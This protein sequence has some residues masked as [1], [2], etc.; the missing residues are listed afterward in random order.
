MQG[1]E[2][3]RQ[4]DSVMDEDPVDG[5]EPYTLDRG[6]RLSSD[7]SYSKRL[8]DVLGSDEEQD[9]KQEDVSDT[10]DEAADEVAELANGRFHA[11]E[12]SFATEAGSSASSMTLR[13]LR[14]WQFPAPKRL[15]SLQSDQSYFST[16]SPSVGMSGSPSVVSDEGSGR[17]S[18]MLPYGER[19]TNGNG[20]NGNTSHSNSDQMLSGGTLNRSFLRMSRLCTLHDQEGSPTVMTVAGGILAVGTRSGK[21]GLFDR[22]KG[23]TGV[24]SVEG[25]VTSLAISSD[26]TFFGIGTSLGHIYLYDFAKLSMPARHVP[27]VAPNSVAT[28]RSEGHLQG[29][30]VLHLSFVG[31]RRTAIVSA[32]ENGLAFYHSLGKILGVSSN[33]TLRILGKY[34]DLFK[35]SRTRKSTILGMSALPL[36]SHPHASDSNNFVALLTPTKMVLVGLK[37]SAKTWY[38]HLS[39]H[40]D[41]RP[42]SGCLAWM[43]SS[44]VAQISSS[45]DANGQ[46]D[47][48]LAF[49]FG[50]HLH[51][52][53]LRS[54]GASSA[55]QVTAFEET[56][57][58]W[59]HAEPIE[60]M[61]WLSPDYLILYSNTHM[62]LF[63]TRIGKCT[64]EQTII[65]P[66]GNRWLEEDDATTETLSGSLKSHKGSLFILTPKEVLA[67]SLITWAD[68]IL[69]LVSTGNFL[70]AIG[71]VTSLLQDGGK[72]GG[73]RVG[74]PEAFS[75]QKPILA[76]RLMELMKASAKYAFS[77]DRMKDD[78]ANQRGGIDRTPLFEGLARVCA[79]A[80]LALGDF[81]YLFDELF[82]MYSEAGIEAIFADQME[83]FIVS[84]QVRV[85]PIPVV[86]RLISIR[87]KQDRLDLAE[88]IIWNVDP[89][90][91]DLDQV[92]GLC[93]KHDLHDALI[94]VYTRALHDFVGPIVELIDLIKRQ[95]SD[96]YRIISYLSITLIGLSYPNQDKLD[97]KEA[98][99]AR[100][101]LYAFLFSGRCVI[102][103]PGPGGRL[104]LTRDID[105]GDFAE[106]TFP[107]LCLMLHYDAEAFLDALDVALEDAWLDE[108]DTT[109]QDIVSILFEVVDSL[110]NGKVF[111]A[112]FIARNAPKYPQFIRLAPNQVEKLLLIL[113]V[114][115]D[116]EEG[117]GTLQDRQFAVECLLSAYRPKQTDEMLDKFASAGFID[118]LRRVYRS[119][120]K[121]DKLAM[122]IVAGPHNEATLDG[123]NE[124]L[125]KARKDERVQSIFLQ[126]LPALLDVDASKTVAV[127]QRYMAGKQREA[128]R[129]LD[130][131][132]HRQLTY[133]R[134]FLDLLKDKPDA[135]DNDTRNLFIS[136]MCSIEPHSLVKTLEESGQ[137]FF[138][139]NKVVEVA[140]E[141]SVMDGL[142]WAR[143]KL[144]EPMEGL[145]E[146]DQCV[147]ERQLILR[148]IDVDSSIVEH[149]ET[150]EAEEQILAVVNMAVRICTE[151][152]QEGLWIALL[153]TVIRSTHDS[154]DSPAADF[155]RLLLEDTLSSFVSSTSADQTSF[156]SLFQKLIPEYKGSTYA[157]VRIISDGMMAANKLRQ[158]LLS[159]TNRLFDR[160][161]HRELVSLTQKQRVGWRPSS[162][163]TVCSG[164]GQACIGETR[165]ITKKRRK[166]RS[167]SVT[168]SIHYRD[169]ILSPRP[170]KGKGV[171]RGEENG[172]LNERH[173]DDGFFGAAS[174]SSH[175]TDP[176]D[177]FS[178]T[179]LPALV[180]TPS[181]EGSLNSYREE[182]QAETDSGGS[183]VE[184]SGQDEGVIV[185]N[186]GAIWHRRCLNT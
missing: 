186:S 28:G 71:F 91:L 111:T 62:S 45:T 98:S 46:M 128:I 150:R 88:R 164:C 127:V 178:S 101:S 96:G 21:V 167:L 166:K 170:D 87:N 92:I 105:G 84:G 107:Y 109:R 146:M 59:T 63:D 174:T 72:D 163:K 151:R 120:G 183:N 112:I 168:R 53:K 162:S 108:G 114:G 38:R 135:I 161:V 118:I 172:G 103:P 134:S 180:R 81:T 139:M 79:Q 102:W 184:N 7:S 142:L 6:D 16:D 126:A 89:T 129:Q 93:L 68:R 18:W 36:G 121:W 32:D 154:V 140:R 75:D 100:S 13:P 136:L 156:S 55:S 80:C 49:S 160:D 52:I 26:K 143:N 17:L 56:K 8:A 125:R 175:S 132:P 41:T 182:Q 4:Y 19:L 115:Q 122:M 85:L 149:G 10:Q 141:E 67:S 47:P 66:V 51:F 22:V 25:I 61:Q 95:D 90:C 130:R 3:K 113:S 123:V 78:M 12:A 152:A 43:P 137:D 119:E 104:V 39:T 177:V 37:P 5:I 60:A 171:L 99:Q 35:E 65:K 82:D 110:Q 27:P 11:G 117:D 73:S 159:I 9:R 157:E 15:R 74:L 133:L 29:T 131:S 94:Y 144:N 2:Y 14:P 106:P 31:I 176:L 158:D 148:N 24:I 1:H 116:D 185:F 83:G 20:T 34:P 50:R 179:P 42:N 44:K 70:G 58:N 138:D 145:R 155:S 181:H 69:A 33:D 76:S 124:V 48:I 165:A 153:K 97:D 86:Q 173:Q 54:I 169:P 23:W 40:S 57:W 77:E 147:S 30:K 64:E